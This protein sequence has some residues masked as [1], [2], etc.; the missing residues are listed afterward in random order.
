MKGP[1]PSNPDTRSRESR[2]KEPP[3]SVIL[4]EVIRLDRKVLA[5]TFGFVFGFGLFLATILLVL[6]GGHNVGGHLRLL[7]EF[8]PGY[9]VTRVGSLIGFAWG[10]LTGYVTG[11]LLGTIYNLVVKLRPHGNPGGRDEK[12]LR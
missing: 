9:R 12:P 3:E 4:H 10:F 5:L 2:P 1:P 11:W 8:F 7:G 6:K